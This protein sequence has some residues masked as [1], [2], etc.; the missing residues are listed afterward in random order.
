MKFQEFDMRA[1]LSRLF[2]GGCGFSRLHLA[3]PGEDFNADVLEAGRLAY[4]EPEK[5]LMPSLE[6]HVSNMLD[7]VSP[8]VRKSVGLTAAVAASVAY[9]Q[10][11]R[12][13]SRAVSSAAPQS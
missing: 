1:R 10:H 12:S 3:D 6:E 5:E 7:R 4:G 9:R 2:N 13:R 11:F 8:T